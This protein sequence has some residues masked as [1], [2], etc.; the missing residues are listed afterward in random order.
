MF[1]MKKFLACEFQ[2]THNILHLMRAYEIEP[3]SPAAID[4]WF[5]R[6]S[7]PG[8]W[9]PELLCIKEMERGNPVRMTEYWGA[10]A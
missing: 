5:Q 1:D 4:K 10:P 8:G 9:L 3:P 6:G 2:T 7:V